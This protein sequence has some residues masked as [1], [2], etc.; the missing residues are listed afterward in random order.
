[1]MKPVDKTI[2]LHSSLHGTA[3]HTRILPSLG[4]EI[5]PIELLE[6]VAP[7]DPE[8]TGTIFSHSSG[9]KNPRL[10]D[11][12]YNSR[13]QQCRE[14]LTAEYLK[15]IAVQSIS[16]RQR[17]PAFRNWA[18][19]INLGPS[20]PLSKA[21]RPS[22]REN[23][24]RLQWTSV[25]STKERFVSIL[26]CET[27]SMPHEEARSVKKALL[28]LVDALDRNGSGGVDYR[29]FLCLVNIV[30]VPEM[31]IRK[32]LKLWF[33]IYMSTTV[34]G[35]ITVSELLRLLASAS[36]NDS[37]HYQVID[38]A[39]TAMQNT[40]QVSE[41]ALDPA[42]RC[43]NNTPQSPGKALQGVLFLKD[44]DFLAMDQLRPPT[45]PTSLVLASKR[46]EVGTVT[47]TEL[48]FIDFLGSAA[49][50]AQILIAM[51]EKQCWKRLSSDERCRIMNKDCEAI[52]VRFS[53]AEYRCILRK[54]ITKF[55]ESELK[56][57]FRRWKKYAIFQKTKKHA[58]F[59]F[60]S[61]KKLRGFP[62]W[63]AYIKRR[64]SLRAEQKRA[65]AWRI[66]RLKCGVFR[67]LRGYVNSQFIVCRIG[68]S[69]L[70]NIL[71]RGTLYEMF[72]KL[73]LHLKIAK[74][75]RERQLQAA[76]A[77]WRDIQNHFVRRV[78]IALKQYATDQKHDREA[79][80]RQDHIWSR[81]QDGIDISGWEC[82]RVTVRLGC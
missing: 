57:C 18:N 44:L 75:E 19:K 62:I 72:T 82:T 23:F 65:D 81:L 63:H 61:K 7:A 45:L 40:L 38:L 64:L 46:R 52:A 24:E 54:A 59:F 14:S 41:A 12:I 32:R 43:Y 74:D 66:F 16:I 9:P 48:A 17:W 2:R 20:C 37:E 11:E 29:E 53:K 79:S 71:Y 50:D 73:A 27:L 33:D 10:K 55:T 51:C 21:P 35:G 3:L 56:K 42:L 36:L 15:K 58:I 77:L 28:K 80:A 1:M 13:M 30:E 26:M 34:M 78:F 39:I 8:T 76:L 22:T 5:D 47:I 60:I 4:L 31:H 25:I 49:Q 68:S 67:A 6:K 70:A 69:L